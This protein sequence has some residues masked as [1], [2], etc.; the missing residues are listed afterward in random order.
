MEKYYLYNFYLFSFAHFNF[1]VAVVVRNH[2]VIHYNVLPFAVY[3]DIVE[4]KLFVDP[5]I[6][7]SKTKNRT[8]KK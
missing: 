6:I 3:Y 4:I 1:I 7:I 8:Y 2:F 5:F